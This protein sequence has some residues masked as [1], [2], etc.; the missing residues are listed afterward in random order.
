MIV[1]FKLAR[2]ICEVD[3]WIQIKYLA[4]KPPRFTKEERCRLRSI[5]LVILK[6]VHG[7][8]GSSESADEFARRKIRRKPIPV[9]AHLPAFLTRYFLSAGRLNSILMQGFSYKVIVV[10][11]LRPL[12]GY[13]AVKHLAKLPEK[14]DNIT[15]IVAHRL[16]LN[17]VRRVTWPTTY[18]LL[19]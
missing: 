1:D 19:L 17:N 10:K 12:F 18:A 11:N 6:T 13:S 2:Q 8:W 9:S 16:N 15:F 3:S 14:F 7:T 4:T 5:H